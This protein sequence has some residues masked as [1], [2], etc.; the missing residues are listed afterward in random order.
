MSPL[1]RPCLT[2]FTKPAVPGRVKTRLIGAAPSGTTRPGLTPAETARLH[3]AFLEDLSA[4]LGAAQLQLQVAWALPPDPVA[5]PAGL[6]LETLTRTLVRVPGAVGFAQEGDSLG[7]RL[8]HGLSR[9]AQYADRVGAVGSDHPDLDAARLEEGFDRLQ[10]AD[11]VLGPAD[12]G[13]YYFLAVDRDRLDR[14]LFEGI[15]WSTAGVL[16]ATLAR[17]HELDLRVELLPVGHDVDT[18]ED[19]AALCERLRNS[20]RCPHTHALLTELAWL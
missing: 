11:L 15:P 19:L 7:D 1:A 2:L 5:D 8:F 6:D 13:G 20:V 9:A 14:R 16:E 10:Q 4:S 3:Q 18:G 12:D 17:A